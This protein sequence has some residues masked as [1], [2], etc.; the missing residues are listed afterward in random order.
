[1]DLAYFLRQRTSL[2]RLL[3]DESVGALGRRKKAIED[4]LEPFEPPPFNPD[5]DSG[6]PPFLSDWID[7]EHAIELAAMVAVSQLAD[8]LKIFFDHFRSDVGFEFVESKERKPFKDG[9][10]AAYKGA[11]QILLGDLFSECP[12]DFAL[13]EQVVFA[14]NRIQHGDDL[15]SFR[16]SHDKRTL[17]RHPN[18]FFADFD[19]EAVLRPWTGQPVVVT[20]DKLMTAIEEI[21]KLG[22]WVEANIGAARRFQREVLVKKEASDLN[23]M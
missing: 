6:E 10:V 20:R 14:R 15:V 9:Y 17:E 7:A 3:Y 8:S 23:D 12:A 19:N 16:T 18:P 4:G 11:L 5:T 1:M 22:D 21:E 2:I 13:I